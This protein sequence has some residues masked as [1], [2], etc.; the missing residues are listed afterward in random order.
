M[1]D[2]DSIFSQHFE[3]PIRNLGLQVLKMPPR[4]PQA[5]AI[6]ERVLGTLRRECLDCM[7]LMTE[8]QLRRLLQEWVQ[9]Y[10]AG[11]PHM[12]LGPGIPQPV[13]D[14]PIP[15]QAH[16]HKV[17]PDLCVVAR[18]ILDG[19]HHEYRLERKVA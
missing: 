5:N 17:P 7:I 14:L 2:R 6:C 11:H 19:L 9:H 18:P 13:S 15:L 3:R 12:A 8:N 1:H 16:R 10:N 4:A